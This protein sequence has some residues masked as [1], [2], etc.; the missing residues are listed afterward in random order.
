MHTAMEAA[1]GGIGRYA[2]NR[3]APY[4]GHPLNPYIGGGIAQQG[5]RWGTKEL[6]FKASRALQDLWDRLD[7]SE[8][9]ESLWTGAP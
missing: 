8:G 9:E 3:L 6:A 1:A 5:V 7:P 2:G 4:V